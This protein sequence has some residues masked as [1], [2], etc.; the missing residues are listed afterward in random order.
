MTLIVRGEDLI[1]PTAAQIAISRTLRQDL[2]TQ[3]V[4]M[5]HPLLSENS[6]TKLS[7]SHDSL[8]LEKMRESGVTRA[9]IYGFLARSYGFSSNKISNFEEMLEE[10]QLSELKLKPISGIKL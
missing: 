4:F 1:N 3:A 7:K 10:F 6:E 2:S 8:S 9:Q 5:H